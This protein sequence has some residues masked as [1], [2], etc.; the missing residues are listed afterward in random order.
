M[1][2]KE[3]NPQGIWADPEAVLR[4]TEGE[5]LASVIEAL[6]NDR[7]PQTM[8][9]GWISQ[10][11]DRLP[12]DQAVLRGLLNESRVELSSRVVAL[13]IEMDRARQRRCE[14]TGE[15]V[16]AARGLAPAE[17]IEAGQRLQLAAVCDDAI[18]SAQDAERNTLR[19]EWYC[20]KQ[21]AAWIVETLN[22]LPLDRSLSS[23]RK[24]LVA[25]RKALLGRIAEI[26]E[27]VEFDLV[28]FLES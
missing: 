3:K 4:P 17:V 9:L 10:A 6:E 18:E 28:M 2:N 16:P 26:E 27:S 8:A 23:L 7:Y 15:P 5:R 24:T 11:L 21:G 12:Q 19:Q 20:Q 1:G 14:C 13:T 22:M 25:T